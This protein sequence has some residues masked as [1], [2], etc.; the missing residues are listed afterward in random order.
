M[1]K[2]YIG[3]LLSLLI[4]LAYTLPA[5][6]QEQPSNS[7]NGTEQDCGLTL[8]GKTI[9]HD[10]REP[11]IGATIYIKEL[12][13]ATASDEYGNYHFH[14]LCQGTYTLKVTYI[15]YE[16]ESYTFR[17]TNSSVRDL[18]LHTDA[19]QLKA[20]EIIGSHV[21]TQA[22]SSE[23]INGRDL[24][25]TRGL[26]FSES[27]KTIAGVTTLQTGPTI[28][29][30]VIHGLHSSRILLL[31][32]GVRQE[33][34]QWGSEH[35]P[36]IDPFVT[37]EMHIVKGAAGVRYGADAVGGVVIV[38]PRPLRDSIG[39]GAELN[40]LGSTNNRQ[41]GISAMIDGNSAKLPP[42]SW[43]L[44]GTFKKAGNAKAPD[45]YLNNTGFEERNFSAALGYTKQNYGAELFFS[46]FH[47]ELGILR[48]SHIGNLTD[49]NNA[50][51]RG[52][53]E[54]ADTADF[55]Y[56]IG[57][58]YQDV[59]HNLFKAKAF[60]NTGEIGK[61]EFIYG[62]QQNTRKEFDVHGGDT[63]PALQLNLTTHTTEA[64]W[65][66]KPIG[67]FSGSVG[68]S[69]VYKHNTYE[70][71]DFLPFYTSIT[72]GAFAAEHWQ[73]NKLQLEAGL[74]YDYTYL[75]VK[76]L[77]N[78]E[79]LIQPEY[80]FN[81][82][83]GT[84]GAL[85]DVGYHLTFGLSATSAWRAPG[86]NELFSEGVH[87]S[88]VAYEVGNPNLDPEQAYNFELSAEYYGNQRF[89][90][91]LSIYNNY[92]SNYIYAAP[93][94]NPVLTLK[95]AFPAYAYKQADASFRGVDLT[96]DFKLLSQLT[97]VSKSSIVRARNLDTDDHLVSIP[98]DRFD[99]KLTYEFDKLGNHNLAD[100]YIGLGG[101][102]VAKQTRTP[103]KSDQDFAPAPAAYFLL[104][105]EAGTTVYFGKQPVE[106]GITGNNLLN[107][108][109]RDY[110]N[111]FRYFAD[112]MGRIIMFRLKIPLNIIKA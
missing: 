47:T 84:L 39:I 53:P 31:N 83:S 50:I 72:A 6:A 105:A 65:E 101:L 1:I 49:L 2:K 18:Q 35:A 16:Q 71:D 88:S 106:I 59:T 73:R 81:N 104:N 12:D 99:N 54:N 56:T 69:T 33:G 79:T 86:A 10:T 42:L 110:L 15:G 62:L 108:A 74:R 66:H 93:L 46:Q 96:F 103:E 76:K 94:P 36:E 55:T 75:Q 111:R 89:N 60:A 7:D 68:A 90:G 92:I 17:I 34:Q 98:S 3:R 24:D 57:R 52:R 11:L 107:T 20:V 19:K 63:N 23:T 40:L 22:Q 5:T 97:W 30:P 32:N 14:H 61:L 26:S 27:L 21:K 38:D 70:Y 64:V 78:N 37:T 80:T 13:R 67:N 51:A 91:T 58:P 102:Y 29:K 25:K 44:Q 100:T 95:G 48:E 77:K 43:R 82:L 112:E 45:Y 4:V 9:D 28:S 85:Y 87:H 41:E 109:Y 8:S